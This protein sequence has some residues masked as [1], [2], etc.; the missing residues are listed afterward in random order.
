MFG[1]NEFAV[2]APSILSGTVSILVLFFLVKHL[3]KNTNIAIL[4]AFTLAI[5]PWHIQFSRSG[6]ESVMALLMVLTGTYLI[7]TRNKNLLFYLGF[8]LLSLSTYT[9]HSYRIFTPLFLLALLFLERKKI[10]LGSKKYAFGF[11]LFLIVSIPI[12]MFS[13]S[14]RGLARAKSE[15]VFS[16]EEF[17]TAKKDFDQKSKKPLRPLAGYIFN[18]KVFYIQK[19]A[20]GYLAHFSPTFLFLQGDTTGRHSQVD[21]GQIYFFDAL[22]IL[23]CLYGFKKTK[24][25]IPSLLLIMLFIAPIPA[26]IV[27]P[28]PHAN[29]SLPMLIPLTVFSS[30]GLYYLLASFRENKIILALLALLIFYSFLTYT[31]LLFIHYP[32]KFAADWQSGYRQMVQK[33]ENNQ[34]SFENVYITNISALPYI[35]VL[36]Y[37][38]YDPA[39]F[40]AEGSDNAFGKYHFVRTDADVYDKGRILYVSPSWQKVDGKQIDA[41]FDT[42]GNNVFNIWEV[43]G[44]N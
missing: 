5:S 26:M 7:L 13:F 43:N 4:S 36:F 35:Y 10:K 12:I 22:L 9:Y 33:V 17:D 24:V 39:S 27:T 16:H 38:K 44:Q 25:K 14:E 2:R 34:Q 18:E 1:L 20:K 15:S 19:A 3:T 29:R 21:M 32:K 8:F 41:I 11:L 37:T 31:H 6:Y 30:A 28:T 40:Q 42:A 23:L